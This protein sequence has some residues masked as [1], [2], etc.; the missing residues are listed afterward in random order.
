[1]WRAGFTKSKRRSPPVRSF[2]ETGGRSRQ[3]PAGASPGG[4]SHRDGALLRAHAGT[5]KGQKNFPRPRSGSRRRSGAEPARAVDRRRNRR[6]NGGGAVRVCGR[7]GAV[8]HAQTAPD[9][10]RQILQGVPRAHLG[11]DGKL[12]VEDDGPGIPRTSF[13]AS[14][15]AVLRAPPAGA[16]EVREWG[17]ISFRSSVGVRGSGCAF[18]PRRARVRNSSFLS[19]ASPLRP[20]RKIL[21]KRKEAGKKG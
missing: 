14:P 20:R 15:P 6:G 10:L 18:F 3:A 12:S 1:M 11:G 17:C 21:Q 4:Q 13:P 2:S 8:F 16:R 19:R 7:K 9:Q 5:G